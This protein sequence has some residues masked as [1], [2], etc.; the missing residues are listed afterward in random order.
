MQ[1]HRFVPLTFLKFGNKFI[2]NVLECLV[3][4]VNR[5]HN[6]TI[7]CLPRTIFKF[8]MC[9]HNVHNVLKQVCSCKWPTNI[10]CAIANELR[11]EYLRSCHMCIVCTYFFILLRSLGSFAE[12]VQSNKYNSSNTTEIQF[13]D[14]LLTSIMNKNYRLQIVVS[15]QTHFGILWNPD[16]TKS[17]GTGQIC[18]LNEGSLYRKPQYNEY[19]GKRPKCS[20]YRGHS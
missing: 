1:R 17:L 20:L 2:D 19:E 9:V 14:A 12:I 4:P 10:K 8:I 6:F 11:L 18:S 13:V 5:T 15:K 7:L 3:W 16:L